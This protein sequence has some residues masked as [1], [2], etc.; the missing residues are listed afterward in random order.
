MKKIFLIFCVAAITFSIACTDDPIEEF[1]LP[2]AAII[3]AEDMAG[4]NEE[5]TLNGTSS[6]DPEGETLTFAWAFISVP[7][8]SA[9]SI[10]NANQATASFTTDLEGSYIVSLTVSDGTDTATDQV[11]VIA[12][13]GNIPTVRITDEFGTDFGDDQVFRPDEQFNITGS[14]SFDLE[15]GTDLSSY[16]WEFTSQPAGSIASPASASAEQVTFS[17]DLV[18]EYI[19]KLTVTDSD[20][21]I[22]ADSV[23][24]NVDRIPIIIS[25]DIATTTTLTNV[26]DDPQFTDYLVT[27]T[28][29]RVSAALTVMPGVTIDFEDDNGIF[30]STDGSLSAVGTAADS[31]I[32][33]GQTGVTGSWRGI[34]LQSNNTANILSY[35]RISDAGSDGFDGAGLKANF[36]VEDDGRV[37]INNT[38]I[39]NG[40]GSGIYIRN[41]ESEIRDFSTNVVTGNV[42][43][44]TCSINQYHFFD[45]ATDFTGNT[46]DYIDSYRGTTTSEDVTWNKLTVPTR[47]SGSIDFIGSAITVQAGAQFLGQSGSGLEITPNGSLNATGTAN[48]MIS[49][50]G[51]QDTEGVWNGLN[52]QSN[53][54]SNNLIYCMI[55]NG[56]QD[57][58]DGAGLKANVF[59]EA[60]GRLV[61]QNSTITKSADAGV[62]I[63]N[64][65]SK[66]PDFSTNTLSDNL[67]PVKS[68]PA[69]WHYLDGQ[70]DYTGNTNDLIDGFGSNGSQVSTVTWQALNVPYRLSASTETW[71]Q[72][73]I[74]IEAGAEISSRADGGIAVTSDAFLNI[75]GTAANPVIMR[76]DQ[77]V[78]GYWKG[79]RFNS[80]N[81]SNVATHLNISN[82]GSRGFDGANRKAN[83]EIGSANGLANLTTVSSTLSGGFGIRIQSSGTMVATGL[84]FSGNVLT[85]NQDNGGTENDNI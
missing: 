2:P 44:V 83:I 24:I 74:T 59:V 31:V 15:D 43:P 81:A 80:N 37:A 52:F 14:F 6:T 45:G 9:A 73:G 28:T 61:I 62:Y 70:S 50:T 41:F 56:G 75:A 25:E 38:K 53:N 46:N 23:T 64:N 60:D 55:S 84:S 21:N 32:F 49:F 27:R 7:T 63:R 10:S 29:L 18:G 34:S 67:F 68:A 20:D 42:V 26:Y 47:L 72:G 3:I 51:E 36:M 8:G 82:G 1:N 65:T 39:N 4:L 57:G 58:F 40:G 33:K 35:V 54:T 85:G 76:G 19:L 78:T 11:T 71:T 79:I 48:E 22:S 5:V 30:V 77:N 12:S 13:A 66:L 69:N 17:M 16:E